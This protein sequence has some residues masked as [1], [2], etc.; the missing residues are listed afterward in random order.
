MSD[1]LNI[2]MY[3]DPTCPYAYSAE[4][5]RWRLKWLYGDQLTWNTRMIVL[6][7]YRTEESDY[8]SADLRKSNIEKRKLYGMPI[9]DK[10][11]DRAPTSALACK[12][13]VAS[14]LNAPE[15]ADDLLRQ[16]RIASMSGE[17]IDEQSVIDKI[18]KGV[19]IDPDLLSKW[20]IADQTESELSNDAEAARTPS[21]VALAM[22]HKLSKTSDGR[23][24]YS[25]PSYIFENSRGAIFELPGFWDFKT[26][27]AAIDNLAP[28][29]H[30]R[31]NPKSAKEVLEWANTPLAT[32]EVETIY[33]NA[34]ANV[35][36][37]L[38]EIADC[39]RLG[40]DGFWTLKTLK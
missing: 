23:I 17:L 9:T 40:Q 3:T 8:A 18:A 37:K 21:K 12:S 19:E 34:D 4:P 5:L 33:Q 39:K 10:L 16:L 26:Y 22:R 25:A 32:K 20:S 13:Y 30:K 14:R 24:R 7:G 27:E 6:S 11:L 1:A 28:N 36:A 31:A 38:A 2:T 29:L 15:K 35:R